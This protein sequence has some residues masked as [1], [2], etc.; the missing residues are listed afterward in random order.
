MI[1]DKKFNIP[2]MEWM[3]NEEVFKNHKFLVLTT[4]EFQ[5]K[6][7]NQI[8]TLES[9]Y[10]KNIISNLYKFFKEVN[11]GDVIIL[12]ALPLTQL[13][14]LLPHKWRHTSWVINGSDLYNSE[15]KITHVFWKKLMISNFKSHLTHIEGDS[16]LANKVFDAN[17]VFKYSPMYL[18]NTVNTNL[19]NQVSKKNNFVILVGNSLSVTNNHL[20]IFQQLSRHQDKID[21]IICPVNYGLESNYKLEVIEMGKFY[22]KEKFQPILDFLPR[23]EYE[24]ILADVDIAVFDHWRQEA[25]GVTLM[26]LSLGKTVYVNKK[27]TSYESFLN[28]GFRIFDNHLIFENGPMIQDVTANKILIEKYYSIE[29]LKESLLSLND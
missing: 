12:H 27:T 10:R 26:L 4:K 2:L 11:S 19:F 7:S 14:F 24:S 21:K 8:I 1:A 6:N 23:S 28:R 13:L 5:L 3:I 18:S 16:I 29:K 20:Y 9:P 25:M 22:F 15:K 17:A